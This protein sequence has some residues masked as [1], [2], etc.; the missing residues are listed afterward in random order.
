MDV[1]I[2]AG[3]VL[4]VVFAF[5]LIIG[6]PIAFTIIISSVA[7]AIV[8]FPMDKSIIIAAQKV[9][10]GVDKL[11]LLAI[12]FFILAGIIMNNGGIA[13]R[14]VNFAKVLSGRM[15][16]SLA[17]T[18]IVGNMLFGA[19]SGSAVAS[20]AAMG[21]ILGPMQEKEG[22]DKRFSATVNIAS[23]PTGLLIPP[24]NVL[25]TYSL[26][27]GGTSVA[28]LFMAG[29]LPGILWGL[30]TMLVAYIIAK[31]NNYPV[32][33]KIPGK[34]KLKLF[35][36]AI[37][38][39]L[40]IIIVI[41]GI[42]AGIFTATEGAAVAVVYALF[43]SMVVYRSLKFKDLPQILL[44]TSK[45]TAIIMF[46]IAGSTIMSYVMTVAGIPQ[47][48][49]ESILGI[50]DNPIAILLIMNLILLLIGTFMDM[51]PAI[52]IFTPILLPIA[53]QLGMDPIHFG[54]MITMNLCIGSITPPVGN[55]LFIG[56]KVGNVSIDSVI[57]PLLPYYF[58][59]IIGLLITTFIPE[60]TLWI[61]RITGNL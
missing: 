18:N 46:L 8:I 58:V 16:G 22:Y 20:A 52:L 54:I 29:Y 23:A 36:D 17:H 31:R 30:L 53:T 57:K 45:T 5:F 19:I 40:L 14:L 4:L 47:L 35:L 38:S 43:L 28:A 25:I 34:L 56:S 51:T 15:P 42:T 60:L 26:V 3:L 10:T 21:G 32:S 6:T 11:T 55:C 9:A 1:A 27:S 41:G 48:I 49:S 2:Q 59:I 33:E 39:L 24:S 50:T 7:T 12:P 44:E 37:P 13:V 61:P